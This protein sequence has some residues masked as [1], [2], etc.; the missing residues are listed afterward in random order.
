MHSRYITRYLWISQIFE[1]STDIS[2]F[3]FTRISHVFFRYT[4]ISNEIST[5]ICGAI[6]RYPRLIEISLVLF[7]DIFLDICVNSIFIK[8]SVT[9]F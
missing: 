8:I 5:D 2:R 7:S 6:S 9:I 1:I 3:G 4:K